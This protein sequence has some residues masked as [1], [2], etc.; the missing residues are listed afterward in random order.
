MNTYEKSSSTKLRDLLDSNNKLKKDMS[1]N[2][3]T[4]GEK[5][6]MSNLKDAQKRKEE[7]EEE[8]KNNV[9]EEKE[10]KGAGEPVKEDVK[11][12]AVKAEEKIM[13]E[14]D[15]LRKEME[16]LLNTPEGEENKTADST[17]EGNILNKTNNFENAGNIDTKPKDT[18]KG[19]GSN[20]YER[21]LKA[22][23]YNQGVETWQSTLLK[24]VDDTAELSEKQKDFQVA[25]ELH[26]VHNC[27]IVE[28]DAFPEMSIQRK[29]LFTKA[30][31]SDTKVPELLEGVSM[32]EYT[33]WKNMTPEARKGFKTQAQLQKMQTNLRFRYVAPKNILGSCI[34]MPAALNITAEQFKTQNF[35]IS[36]ETIKD[37][38]SITFV[39]SYETSFTIM[40]MYCG[41]KMKEADYMSGNSVTFE[42]TMPDQ[43]LHAFYN[44]QRRKV[45]GEYTT[46]TLKSIKPLGRKQLLVRE[47]IV[48][49]KRFK[50]ES[51]YSLSSESRACY[52]I[53]MC[54]KLARMNEKDPVS[55]YEALIGAQKDLFSVTEDPRSKVVMSRVQLNFLTSGVLG[56]GAHEDIKLY[57]WSATDK[58]GA[59]VR[60]RVIPD[61]RILALSRKPKRN[62]D[63]TAPSK[64]VTTLGQD[65]T[66][67]SLTA[68]GYLA[69][70]NL[71]DLGVEMK[72]VF[73]IYSSY[74][75]AKRIARQQASINKPVTGRSAVGRREAKLSAEDAA[76]LTLHAITT[77]EKEIATGLDFGAATEELRRITLA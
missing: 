72:E 59:D 30:Q 60:K 28:Q 38:D 12:D 4:K 67:D 54:K 69:A 48:P 61:Y 29:F 47:N 71:K 9:K 70:K 13:S 7:K 10:V 66:L 1:E 21:N 3:Q 33:K 16:D 39:V 35:D 74:I 11:E 6:H 31:N 24:S 63:V 27:F 25:A 18:E 52:E 42:K 23:M 65:Y 36:K 55:I 75:E 73:D 68:E 40:A 76:L 43:K 15:V 32:D 64:I 51:L 77:N 57:D 22:Q 53:N 20:L 58:V 17:P 8:L 41:G 44:P 14:E 62:G 37:S 56:K 49:I 5:E 19:S 45:N 26:M 34:T 46:V 2:D 50:T